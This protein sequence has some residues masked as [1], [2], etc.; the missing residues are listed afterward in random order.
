MESRGKN[1]DVALKID[2]SKAYDRIDWGLLEQML[3]RVGFDQSWVRLMMLCI[4]TVS[5]SK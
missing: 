4:S 5:P 2:V 1:G 3:L